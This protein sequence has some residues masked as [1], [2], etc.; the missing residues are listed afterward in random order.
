MEPSQ[1]PLAGV[2]EKLRNA[3]ENMHR[4][5]TASLLYLNSGPNASILS[6][7]DADDSTRGRMRFNVIRQ[8]PLKLAA[9]AGDVVH[10]V[11][12]SLDYFVEELVKSNGHTP[13]FQNL[14]PICAKPND[15][16]SAIGKGRLHGIADRGVRVIDGFQPYQVKPE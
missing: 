1:H 16:S 10:N 4:L 8:P 15:F 2:V 6:E 5:E 7:R 14:F 13:T 12:S 3:D 11:R 9:I